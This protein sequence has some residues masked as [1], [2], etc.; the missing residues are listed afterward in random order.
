MEQIHL[1]KKKNYI[2]KLQKAVSSGK[3]SNWNINTFDS[4]KLNIY[5]QSNYKVESILNSHREEIEFTI[6]KEFS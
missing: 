5:V 3:I 2:E 6:Y 4:K 1:E